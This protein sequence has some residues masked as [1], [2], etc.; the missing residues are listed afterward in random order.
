MIIWKEAALA[1][2]ITENNVGFA[3]ASLDEI[4]DRLNQMTAEDYQT[5]KQ[6]TLAV[7]EKLRSGYFIKTAM[8]T[9]LKELKE[10]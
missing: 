2:F 1:Q 3:V 10:N 8:H 6:N 9:A 4:N 7:A 5:M